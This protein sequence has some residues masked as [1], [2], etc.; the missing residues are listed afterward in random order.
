LHAQLNHSSLINATIVIFKRVSI[1]TM[2]DYSERLKL[3]LKQ[4]GLT[5]Q[6][7]ADALGISY[8]ATKK[9]VDGKTKAFTAANSLKAARVMGVSPDWLA[10]GEG[11]V[12]GPLRS[13]QEIIDGTRLIQIFESGL[14]LDEQPPGLIKGWNVDEDWLR[15]NV[16]SHTGVHNL[17][18]VT[19]F[20][21]SMQPMFCAGDPL[22]MDRG[23]TQCSSD[24]VYFFRIGQH[25][26]IKQLQHIP[27]AAGLVIRA[28][29]INKAYE[30]FDITKGM[31]FEVL[32]RILL[33]WKSER[34]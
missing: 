14:T 6:M 27:T 34:V 20:G 10:T 4:S 28:T 16:P 24:G 21:S 3:A 23:V 12:K 1:A 9:A 2:V 22:L 5:I 19:G 8:Q 15:R 26:Y 25:G 7:L 11:E 30:S 29:S 13:V 33:A 17:R 18:L 31:D 32:G